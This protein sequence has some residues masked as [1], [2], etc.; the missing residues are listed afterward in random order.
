[1][2]CGLTPAGPMERRSPCQFSTRDGSGAG[3]HHTLHSQ[4]FL[5]E[6]QWDNNSVS[7]QVFFIMTNR[8]IQS[9]CY[10]TYT[11]TYI[12]LW[13]VSLCSSG[14]PGRPG[15][16]STQ[17]SACLCL[18][19]D[20]IKDMCHYDLSISIFKKIKIIIYFSYSSFHS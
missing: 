14:C 20:G 5:K 11:H 9:Q 19:S 3:S 13:T 15:W 6:I 8:T 18:P 17:R 12:H 16:P 4:F 7:H 10:H 1:M 2:P